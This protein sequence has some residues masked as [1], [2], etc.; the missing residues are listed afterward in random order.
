[1]VV[2]RLCSLFQMA[3]EWTVKRVNLSAALCL[4]MVLA[5]VT[6]A[7][8]AVAQT[9]RLPS[10]VGAAGTSKMPVIHPDGIALGAYDPHGDFSDVERPR[11]SISFF[12]GS[13]LISRRCWRP[14]LMQAAAAGRSSS[15]SNPGLG[16]RAGACPRKTCGTRS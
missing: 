5:A 2:D 11:S 6:A 15:Q 9:K 4:G 10:E 1:V 3:E 13:T 7:C 8:P 14:M 16:P 12:L